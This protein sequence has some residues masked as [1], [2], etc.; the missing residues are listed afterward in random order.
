MWLEGVAR[1]GRVP[2]WPH[3]PLP[4]FFLAYHCGTIFGGL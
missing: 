1:V 3:G 4:L 2:G